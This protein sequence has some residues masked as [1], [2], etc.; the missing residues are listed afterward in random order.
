MCLHKGVELGSLLKP[1]S[2]HYSEDAQEMSFL[3]RRRFEHALCMVSRR[4]SPF[5]RARCFVAPQAL[6]FRVPPALP[7]AQRSPVVP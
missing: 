4:Q 7:M 5:S 1:P 6:L 3:S 2:S